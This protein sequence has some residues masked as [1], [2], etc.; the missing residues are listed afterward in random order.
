[1]SSAD[2][3]RYWQPTWLAIRGLCTSMKSL[4]IL[5][6]GAVSGDMGHDFRWHHYGVWKANFD[7][8]IGYMLFTRP[9]LESRIAERVGRL[10][11][12]VVLQGVIDGLTVD[13]EHKQITGVRIRSRTGESS[14]LAAD[15]I[16]DATGRG[17]RTP[18]WLAAL[19]FEPPSV[20]TVKVDVMYASRFY[21]PGPTT[22]NLKALL[23]SPRA[24]DKRTGAIFAVEGN[25][26]L[27][28]LGGFHGVQPPTDETGYLEFARSLAV[29]DV[30]QA[31]TVAEPLTPITT[32]NFH[33][34]TR[35][36]YDGLKSFPERLLVMGDAF[37]SFNP[38][39][40]QGMTVSAREVL[41]LDAA[42]RERTD[43]CR[44]PARF[45]SKIAAI[46]DTAWGPTTGEDFR[47]EETEGE[48]PAGMALI[49]WYTGRIHERCAHDTALARSF[50][51]VMHMI[52]PP[53]ALFRP[54]VVARAL[55]KSK[56]PVKLVSAHNITTGVHYRPNSA[57]F[58]TL[59]RV[60]S[61]NP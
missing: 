26:W 55:R 17:S 35:R 57:R 27:V 61:S 48:R 38:I 41:A 37:C 60:R 52:D 50:Y 5:A 15:L 20:S 47:Y 54:S 51:R 44:L 25:R 6:G 28:T 14:V 56:T 10:S 18:Q 32:H 29:P 43:L 21:R 19:G 3:R 39:Y 59:E 58:P 12:V 30:Y 22:R 7:S 33:T 13:S 45:H 23:I 2:C 53:V 9:Y 42:L 4:R 40:G 1:V 24:P 46:V 36:H 16:V 34:N 31:I 11:N 8:G 49:H